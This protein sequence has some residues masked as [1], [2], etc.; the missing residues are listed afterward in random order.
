MRSNCSTTYLYVV[1]YS[2]HYVLLCI[3]CKV[4]YSRFISTRELAYNIYSDFP[5][6]FYMEFRATSLEIIV[7]YYKVFI[8]INV[9]IAKFLK[10]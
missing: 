7:Q 6:R 10:C 4:T 9:Y 1:G 5:M 2:S 8:A 3:S